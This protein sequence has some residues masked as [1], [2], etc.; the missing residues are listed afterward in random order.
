[1][2]SVR[3]LGQ[4]PVVLA[5]RA[6]RRW[7]SGRGVL[8]RV[9][10]TFAST[11]SCSAYGLRATSELA[12][13]LPDAMRL[14]RAR[15]RACRR[16]SLYRFSAGLGWERDHELEPAALARDLAVRGERPETIAQVLAARTLIARWR[17]ERSAYAEARRLGAMADRPLP[18]RAGDA[19][20]ARY[21]RAMRRG[22]ALVV[23]AAVAAV[24]FSALFGL[25]AVAGLAAM[26]NA[27]TSAQRLEQQRVAARFLRPA[28]S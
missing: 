20:I 13:S 9:C 24:L 22:V 26:S 27:R 10:C 8:R 2:R 12:T 11:E 1:M 3:Y 16:T 4:R 14:V 19:A 6:Y 28:T 17:G 15:L 21:R 5:I 23:L 25:V 7:F 18:V